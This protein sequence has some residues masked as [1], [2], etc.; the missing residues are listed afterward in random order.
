MQING[1][2]IL[3]VIPSVPLYIC[4]WFRY[5]VEWQ[6]KMEKGT[7]MNGATDLVPIIAG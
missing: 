3:F 4:R 7:T 2:F 6:M 5:A 1:T